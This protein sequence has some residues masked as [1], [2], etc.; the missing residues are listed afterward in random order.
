[1]GSGGRIAKL[2]SV[3]RHRHRSRRGRREPCEIVDVEMQHRRQPLDRQGGRGARRGHRVS[4][5]GRTAG[6][7]E[8]HPNTPTDRRLGRVF[9]RTR[10]ASNGGALSRSKECTHERT[11]PS[12]DRFETRSLPHSDRCERLCDR[13]LF[14]QR[15]RERFRDDKL[16][17]RAGPA[18]P[19]SLHQ[20]SPSNSPGL[21]GLGL[22]MVSAVVDEE[23]QQSQRTRG[24][25]Q[26]QGRCPDAQRPGALFL[27]LRR[28]I[29]S[30]GH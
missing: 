1:M 11:V 22:S 25:Q 5:F 9:Q 19:H 6:A 15:N 18:T 16:Q 27:P 20:G 12:R 13:P 7:G 24:E 10:L 30:G 21:E 4:R 2:R 8:L 17:D 23:Q 14:A 3:Q 26:H 28:G 29:R